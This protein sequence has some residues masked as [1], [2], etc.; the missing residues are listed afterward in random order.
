MAV[1]RTINV[2]SYSLLLVVTKAICN[3]GGISLRNDLERINNE[4]KTGIMKGM[5][6][7][8]GERICFTFYF[9]TV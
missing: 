2:L 4:C 7:S 8:L 9:Y 6:C 3:R 1:S 5:K